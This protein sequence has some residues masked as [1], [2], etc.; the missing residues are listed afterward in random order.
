MFE[1]NDDEFIHFNKFHY[2]ERVPIV[3]YADFECFLKPVI[4]NY[5]EKK[6]NTINT[7]IHKPMSYGF[8]VKI[9]YDFVPIELVKKFKLPIKPRIYRGKKYLKISCYQL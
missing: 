7:H 3:I 6:C 4:N 5:P 1:E 2:G 8:Y 9:N